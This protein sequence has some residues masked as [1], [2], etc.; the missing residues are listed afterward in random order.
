MQ[1]TELLFFCKSHQAFTFS[2]SYY[3][4]FCLWFASASLSLFFPPKSISLLIH[5]PSQSCLQ[6][7]DLWWLGSILQM[8][9][10]ER[11]LIAPT[12][13]GAQLNPI[14]YKQG[15]CSCAPEPFWPQGEKLKAFIQK[16][17]SACEL[18]DKYNIHSSTIHNSKNNVNNINSH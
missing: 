5:L 1:G 7:V 4:V 16:H 14:S 11:N 10:P 12:W 9:P 3:I 8:K 15:A 17:L 6:M 18:W 13:G 2:F